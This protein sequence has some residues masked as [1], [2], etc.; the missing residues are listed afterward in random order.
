LQVEIDA[1]FFCLVAPA[2]SIEI[3][4]EKKRPRVGAVILEFGGGGEN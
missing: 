4:M 2:L 3:E 1:P